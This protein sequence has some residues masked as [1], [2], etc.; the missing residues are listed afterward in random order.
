M[1]HAT[2]VRLCISHDAWLWERLRVNVLG[3]SYASDMITSEAERRDLAEL[4]YEAAEHAMAKDAVESG[5][6]VF[7]IAHHLDNLERGYG[8][9]QLPGVLFTESQLED[10]FAGLDVVRS[11]TVERFVETEAGPQT[12]VDVVYIGRKP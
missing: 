2:T 7:V 3:L 10:D 11:E 12:A 4:N 6:L 1:V 5:G 9:P 8:G